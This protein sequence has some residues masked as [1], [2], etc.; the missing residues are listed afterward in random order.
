MKNWQESVKQVVTINL[1]L[2]TA[3]HRY[4]YMMQHLLQRYVRCARRPELPHIGDVRPSPGDIVGLEKTS[5]KVAPVEY[6][7]RGKVPS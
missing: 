2:G 6:G 1:Q 7:I 4:S 5:V 3:L